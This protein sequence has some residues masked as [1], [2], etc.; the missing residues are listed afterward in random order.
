MLAL[1]NNIKQA[2]Y[3]ICFHNVFSSQNL[4]TAILNISKWQNVLC[5][6]EKIFPF[7]W[8]FNILVYQ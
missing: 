2:I 8:Q 7:K 5:E 3:V 4:F 1:S 6:K